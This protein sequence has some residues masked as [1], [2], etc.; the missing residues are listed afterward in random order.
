MTH[1]KKPSARTEG[2]GNQY[3]TRPPYA[4]NSKLQ[5][6]VALSFKLHL[7]W[8]VWER[9]IS[10]RA[11][12]IFA[13]L[14]LRHHNGKTDRCNPRRELLARELNTKSLD[15]I[16]RGIAE[17]VKAGVL[18]QKLTRGA[19]Y[20]SFPQLPFGSATLP[21]LN[22]GRV[23]TFAAMGPQFCGDG[24]ADLPSGTLKN[25]ELTEGDALPSPCNGRASASQSR[26]SQRSLAW[27]SWKGE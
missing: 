24:S 3:E 6:G 18:I 5:D 15:T 13:T 1:K 25:R 14:L 16:S 27:Q 20:Y 9:P 19:P 8:S 17:L 2:K 26:A 21:T 11:K 7:V 12:T 10:F 4:G 23:R 22:Q